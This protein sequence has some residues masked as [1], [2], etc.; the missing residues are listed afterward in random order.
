M[1]NKNEILKTIQ[2]QKP[3]NPD[4]EKSVMQ[5]G[6]TIALIVTIIITAM[7]VC[8]EFYIFRKFDYGKPAIVALI[9]TISDL[10]EGIKIKSIRRIVTGSIAAIIFVICFIMYVT[11]LF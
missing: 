10:Y 7:M 6:A 11:G 8:I 9:C 3:K 2:E 4:R 1:D 5:N